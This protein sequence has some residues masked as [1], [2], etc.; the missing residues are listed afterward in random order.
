[1]PEYFDDQRDTCTCGKEIRWSALQRKWFHLHNFMTFCTG[2]A[3]DDNHSDTPTAQPAAETHSK[4]AH[5]S[6]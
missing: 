6:V 1:M 4:A 5:T 3:L 2:A